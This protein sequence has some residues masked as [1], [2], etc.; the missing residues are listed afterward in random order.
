MLPLP[1]LDDQTFEEIVEEA[2]RS[3]PRLLPQWTDENAHDPGITL[4][5]LFSWLSEL[6]QYYLNR[7]TTDSELKFLQLLGVKPRPPQRAVS[8]VTFEQIDRQLVLPAGAKLAAIE[9]PFETRYPILLIA[10]RLEKVL[11]RDGNTMNDYTS[12]NEN[13]G[14]SYYAFGNQAK[15]GNRLYIGFNEPLI[16]DQPLCLSVRLF[17][18]Y[19][20]APGDVE[21]ANFPFSPSAKVSWRYYGVPEGGDGKHPSW[22]P[23][24]LLHDGT[25]HLTKSGRIEFNL[26]SEMRPLMLQPANDRGRYW[27]SCTVEEEGY[28]I[29]PK[30]EY[31]SVNTATV[32]QQN[33]ISC[34][35]HFDGTGEMEQVCTLQDYLAYYGQLTV[36]VMEDDGYWYDWTVL[37]T[38]D[39]AADESRDESA[40]DAVVRRVC[41]VEKIEGLH[42]TRIV[43]GRQTAVADADVPA[44]GRSNIR[45]TMFEPSFA[46]AR[47][48]GHS[49]G[50]PGQT[51]AL[52][53]EQIVEEELLIQLGERNEE[54]IV[55]WEDWMRV[56]DFDRSQPYDRH[57]TFDS[58]KGEIRF[59]DNEKGLSP[60]P[61][62]FPNIRMLG[63]VVGGG[64]RGNVKG[65]MIQRIVADDRCE[66]KDIR[67][68]NY[69]HATGGTERETLSA[70]KSRIR[71]EWMTP[72]RAVTGADYERIVKLTPGC[73]VA[74]VKAIP[75]YVKGLREYP[76]A[77]AEGQVTV[78]VVPYS[79][80]Q[81]PMPSQGFLENVKAHLERHRLLGTEIHVIPPAYCKIS[82]QATVVMDAAARVHAHDIRDELNRLFRPLDTESGEA[83]W[84]FGR[85]VYVGDV[86]GAINSIPGVAYV[87]DLWID[88]E[89]EGVRKEVNG[90]II[91]PPYG[92]VY[93]GDHLIETIRND[94]S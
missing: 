23:V 18:R 12:S 17:E 22:L 29:P 19:P 11:V 15:K 44:V 69:D 62:D 64:S 87:Q 72:Q 10:N 94:Q 46:A 84:D 59:G 38:E 77:K 30:V 3:I 20:I 63:C 78:V 92:L 79:P 88:G 31:I 5:E 37:E 74:R 66:Y 40:A 25:M 39:A 7:I 83:G 21:A 45:V 73:R 48:L 60:L 42:L 86:Y 51:V 85:P 16:Q 49:N 8:E 71:T 90:D 33:T 27:L 9:Q 47:Y 32:I 70:A 75:L 76:K 35:R 1:N 13:N 43:F 82:V 93:S 58:E 80:Y 91:L 4:I 53:I 89:G 26:S 55:V 65:G 50:L 2:R 81:K 61:S 36:Q 41:L 56:D 57:Y 28:E 24:Q 68:T 34:V 54:G 52:G 14:V 6:Q 67:V